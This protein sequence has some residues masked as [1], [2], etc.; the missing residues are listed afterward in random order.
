MLP[1]AGGPFVLVVESLVNGFLVLGTVGD[2]R[3]V[4]NAIKH[5]V[6]IKATP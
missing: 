1:D 3:I 6:P 4:A 2:Q 5:A